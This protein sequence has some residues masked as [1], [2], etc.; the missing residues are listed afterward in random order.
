MLGEEVGVEDAAGYGDRAA[1]LRPV[2]L[3]ALQSLRSEHGVVV[4]EGAGGAAEINL[5]GRDLVNLP[6]AAAAGIPAVLVVDIDRG[7]AFASA[8]GSW[9]LLPE[10]LRACLRGFVINTFRGDVILLEP[11]LRDLE[12]RTGLPVLGVLPHLGEEPMLGVEDSLD[13]QGPHRSGHLASRARANHPQHTHQQPAAGVPAVGNRSGPLRVTVVRLPHLANPSDLDPLALEPDVRLSWATAPGD[14]GGADLV[15]LPGSRAT[16]RDLAWL[17]ERGL[18]DELV[19]LGAD[20]AG[21]HLLGICAGYQMLGEEI[22][23]EVESGLGRVAGLG[24]LPVRTVLRGPRK[25]VQRSAGRVVG[26]LAGWPGGPQPAPTA[27]VGY[28]IRWGAPQVAV[29]TS[30]WLELDGGEPEG[31]VAAHGRVVG[32]SLHGVLDADGLRQRLLGAVAACR[33]GT[34]VGS[35]TPY[36]D[37]LDAHLDR[38][39][40]WVESHLDV[41]ALRRLAATATPVGQ[42]PGWGWPLG[43]DD[44]VGDVVGDVVLQRASDVLVWQVP[45]GWWALSS[46]AVGG[47]LLRPRWVLNAGVDEGFVRTDLEAWAGQT[48]AAHGLLGP[49]CA[50]LT[51]ADVSQVAHVEHEGV[52]VWATVGVTKPTWALA[53]TGTASRPPSPGTVN[54]VVSVPVPLSPSALVQ[55][56]GTL[57]E[58]KAQVLVQAG[59]PG[60]GTASDAAVVLCPPTC[61]PGEPVPFAGVRSPWGQRIAAAVHAAVAAGLAAHPWPAPG[62]DPEARW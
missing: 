31:C 9:A 45:A 43:P 11:G 38:L 12:A 59:V 18:A 42:E 25:T 17:R 21:P 6:L 3:E 40:D 13:L 26:H 5:L 53:P 27:V 55:A 14:L 20:P 34:F 48:A 30:P 10:H 16:V 56:L 2:V 37:A 58:A 39:A 62:V 50:L 49:G 32:T 33:G 22:D 23:D 41:G 8:Y 54:V 36:A 7:G 28:Q 61:P 15:V 51:A 52:Q 60:T 1:R 19:R 46:A 29:G 4:L 24:L 47:G 44:R 35:R 57:T